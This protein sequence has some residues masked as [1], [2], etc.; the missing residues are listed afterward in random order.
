MVLVDFSP[1][2]YR[3]SD[4]NVESKKCFPLI[5][6]CLFFAYIVVTLVNSMQSVQVG[7][8]VNHMDFIR[9]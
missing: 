7:I 3:V 2:A 9:D 5:C 6:C 8:N 4:K 1:K